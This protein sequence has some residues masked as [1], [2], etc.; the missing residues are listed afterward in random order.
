V[1]FALLVFLLAAGCS[2][3]PDLRPAIAEPDS[4]DVHSYANTEQFRVRH[5]ALDLEVL[6][7]ESILKGSATLSLDRKMGSGPL[8]LDTR[9]LR[10]ERVEV[11][12]DTINYVETEFELGSV[13]NRVD[14]LGLIFAATRTKRLVCA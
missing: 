3:A 9:D 12:P 5:L 14:A 2:P 1:S 8:V 10:I 13:C 7:D 4:E 6:F 11:S